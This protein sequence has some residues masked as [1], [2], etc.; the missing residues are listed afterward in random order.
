MTTEGQQSAN[1]Q[2]L[3][4]SEDIWSANSSCLLSASW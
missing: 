4:S 1:K 3:T 2:Y